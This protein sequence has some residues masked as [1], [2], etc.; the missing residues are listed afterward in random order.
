MCQSI[1]RKKDKEFTKFCCIG[2]P[3]TLAPELLEV[4]EVIPSCRCA[5][6]RMRVHDAQVLALLHGPA[7]TGGDLV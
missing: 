6:H 7:G 2:A 1:K 3:L 4:E 5:P